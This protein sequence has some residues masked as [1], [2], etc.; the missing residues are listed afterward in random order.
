MAQQLSQ[1]L[2]IVLPIPQAGST[3]YFTSD[4]VLSEHT[5]QEAAHASSNTWVFVILWGTRTEVCTLAS[6]RPSLGCTDI[7]RVNQ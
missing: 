7:W 1:C 5:A 3:G 4:P 6:D 2:G